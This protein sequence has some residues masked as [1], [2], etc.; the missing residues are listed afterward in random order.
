MYAHLNEYIDIHFTG[1]EP[2]ISSQACGL[3]LWSIV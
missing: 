3:A 2:A 1:V